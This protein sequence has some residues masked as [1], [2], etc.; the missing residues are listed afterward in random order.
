M[1]K[2]NGRVRIAWRLP[3]RNREDLKGKQSNLV[4]YYL[5]LYPALSLF[6]TCKEELRSMYKLQ[7]KEEAEKKLI[8][9]IREMKKSEYPEL[10]QWANALNQYQEYILNYFDHHTT[11]ATTEGLHRKYKLIQRTAYGFRNPEVY[12]RRILLACLHLTFLPQ[13]LT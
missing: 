1:V 6:Y 7:T 3:M 11:N 4:S 12:A 9:I 2:G 10:W 13:Y 8:T 5:H